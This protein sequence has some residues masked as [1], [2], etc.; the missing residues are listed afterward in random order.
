MRVCVRFCITR[1]D[2]NHICACMGGC[3]YYSEGMGY[4]GLCV[5][6]LWMSECMGESVYG[7]PPVRVWV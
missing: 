2:P 3:A 5:H 4:D 7:F 1:L 6:S